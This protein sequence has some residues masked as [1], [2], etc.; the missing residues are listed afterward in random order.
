MLGICDRVCN[1]SSKYDIRFTNKLT[2]EDKNDFKICDFWLAFLKS[3]YD[4]R[5][6]HKSSYV[7]RFVGE[8]RRRRA[9]RAVLHAAVVLLL[10]QS[11]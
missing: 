4:S 9:C 5:C 10:R 2:N 8:G 6:R 11:A 3:V 7:Y 1:S